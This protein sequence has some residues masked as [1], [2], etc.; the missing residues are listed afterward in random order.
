MPRARKRT[1]DDTSPVATNV[2][3]KVRPVANKKATKKKSIR[4]GSTSET[5]LAKKT[6]P[7]KSAPNQKKSV[8]VNKKRVTAKSSKASPRG[9]LAAELLYGLPEK[10]FRLVNRR[11]NVVE[12]VVSRDEMESEFQL[13][14]KELDDQYAQASKAMQKVTRWIEAGY[15]GQNASCTVALRKKFGNIVSPLRYVIEVHVPF[16]VS[17]R[18][19]TKWPSGGPKKKMAKSATYCVPECVDDVLTKVVET[20]PYKTAAT[21]LTS[22]IIPKSGLVR[23]KASKELVDITSSPATKLASTE[24]IGG[25]PTVESN[26]GNWGTFGIAFKDSAGTKSF[27]LANAHFAD[28]TMVQ[29]ALKPSASDVSIWDIGVVVAGKKIEKN[30]TGELNNEKFYVDAT[31][32]ALNNKRS[33]VY[34]LVHDFKEESFLYARTYL[35]NSHSNSNRSDALKK[36]FKF[37][38]R[39][40]ERLEGFIENPEDTSVVLDGSSIGKVIRARRNGSSQF[41]LGGDS[42]SVLVAPIVDLKTN[43]ERFLVVGLCFGGLDGD[44]KTLYACQFAAVIKALGLSIPSGLLRDTWAYR[45]T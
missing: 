29:P 2:H 10:E 18:N 45:R 21:T 35:R 11:T 41:T 7:K 5:D 42:G 4:K 37:G 31:L 8:E 36:V 1:T 17:D 33:F 39:T 13:R 44:D 40:K 15:F 26:K 20:R 38:A 23:I 30:I 12:R 19:L 16:K 32:L 25:L 9:S 14:Q 34:N 28:G 3:V 6:V 24:V 27:G 22:S 43:K